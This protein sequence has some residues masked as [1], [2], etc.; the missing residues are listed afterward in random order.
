M[1]R[2]DG[3]ETRKE[4]IHLI[5]QGIHAALYAKKEEGWIPLSKTVA[6]L[7]IDTGLTKRKVMEILML[8]NEAGNFELNE[9]EDKISR[10]T[11]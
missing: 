7:M 9:T 1:V 11:E 4:R 5:N 2:Q 10:A 8:L 6:T 3:A